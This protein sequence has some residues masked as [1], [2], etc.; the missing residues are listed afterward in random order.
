MRGQ[1]TVAGSRVVP[2]IA[3][4]VAGSVTRIAGTALVPAGIVPVMAGRLWPASKWW[5]AAII[6]VLAII[7]WVM[8]IA[9]VLGACARAPATG[10]SSAP[11]LAIVAGTSWGWSACCSCCLSALQS[12][13]LA[14]K[15]P[16]AGREGGPGHRVRLLVGT[17]V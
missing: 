4:G 17:I 5:A 13:V 6:A 15:T 16:V 12:G 1:Q 14:E 7:A 9:T 2:L 3:A 11:R 8:T 10:K